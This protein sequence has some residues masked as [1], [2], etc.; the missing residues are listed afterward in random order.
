MAQG[1]L[2]DHILK[3]DIQ[4]NAPETA[5]R[6]PNGDHGR[7]SVRG[8]GAE[9]ACLNVIPEREAKAL[10]EAGKPIARLETCKRFICAYVE[11]IGIS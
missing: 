4:Q 10:H 2:A 5:R 1:A 7:L 3:M 9:L 11:P 6:C 8:T